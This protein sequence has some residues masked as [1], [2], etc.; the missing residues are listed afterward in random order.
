MKDLRLSGRKAT[1]HAFAT[2]LLVLVLWCSLLYIGDSGL[3]SGDDV[4]P[5]ISYD[6]IQKTG[7]DGEPETFE[8]ASSTLPIATDA[9]ALTKSDTSTL[10]NPEGE[11]VANYTLDLFA[12][13]GEG[14]AV[15][16]TFWG[17]LLESAEALG[18]AGPTLKLHIRIVMGSSTADSQGFRESTAN[19][20]D[21]ISKL[22]QLGHTIDFIAKNGDVDALVGAI[23]ESSNHGVMLLEDRTVLAPQALRYVLQTLAATHGFENLPSAVAG[24]S[25]LR[26][27]TDA[28]HN[29]S[30]Q[31]PSEHVVLQHPSQAVMFSPKAWG[32]FS[33]WVEES[34]LDNPWLP[35]S[36]TNIW[37][38]RDWKKHLLRWM[39]QH[40]TGL[41]FAP[42]GLA[43]VQAHNDEAK[44]TLCRDA[45][46]CHFEP[47]SFDEPIKAKNAYF[48]DVEQLKE[49]GAQAVARFDK[50]IF[51]MPV[52]SRISTLHERLA[53]YHKLKELDSILLV[54]N[55]VDMPP[56]ATEVPGYDIPVIISKEA[57][58]NLNN[59]FRADRDLSRDCLI[60]MDDDWDMPFDHL[61][62]A[63]KAWRQYGF[64]QLV[65]Y[66]HM[67]RKHVLKGNGEYE[68]TRADDE[69]ASI[70]LPSGM[71]FHRKMLDLYAAEDARAAR[72]M[73]HELMNC[74]DILINVL[75][76]REFKTP[77]VV[78]DYSHADGG[79]D[80]G[81]LWHRPG[82][83]EK[84]SGCLSTFAKMFNGI[85]LVMGNYTD[86]ATLA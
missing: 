56:N 1:V 64:E 76:S 81:G 67:A 80:L 17:S 26:P 60:S 18:T 65:G 44:S 86:P 37:H 63:I 41:V 48:E 82:H 57:V 50:C 51:M 12:L 9:H 45:E 20:N 19:L 59:R 22:E 85:Q 61:Q 34:K 35:N 71:V 78:L 6:D 33:K 79:L 68:Y 38:A 25:L 55:N 8:V 75:A 21:G 49:M 46:T 3:D 15:F 23:G 53:Y 27:A 54:W 74:E 2:I 11:S 16:S 40:G 4:T 5:D 13:A 42:P 69:G 84:R 7:K 14:G 29:T 10:Q 47:P 24:V 36:R 73:V 72:E 43:E 66:R 83:L 39:A 70:V 62:R 28:V 30:L 31:L 52:Y 77:P 32:N 58:N